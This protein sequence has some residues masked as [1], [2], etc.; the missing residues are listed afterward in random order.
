MR[1]ERL[2]L[3]LSRVKRRFPL[4]I[5]S[6]SLLFLYPVVLAQSGRR[7]V[8]K[9]SAPPPPP[10]AASDETK[11]ET[12]GEKKKSDED[13]IY[14][15]WEVDKK[16]RIL[17]RDEYLPTYQRGC[18]GRVWATVRVLLHWTGKITE[19]TLIKGTGC[20]Y[21]REAIRAARKLKFEPAMKDGRP[22]SQYVN[23]EY[24]TAVY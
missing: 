5:F 24:E 14:K 7:P 17:N 21:D 20:D 3:S 23:V 18:R 10:P 11:T 12:K 9:E 2:S 6:L 13:R 1:R 4:V 15:S 8:K 19:A 22:V 16:A